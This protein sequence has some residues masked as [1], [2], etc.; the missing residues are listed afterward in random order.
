MDE[1]GITLARRYSGGGAVYQDLGCTTFTFLHEL[2]GNEPVSRI[3]DSNFDMLVSAFRSLNLPVV[4]KGRND[5]VVDDFKVSGSAFKQTSDRLIHH[6]TILVTTDLDRLGKFLTPSKLKLKSKGIS[7]VAARVS[8]LSKFNSSVE[9]ESVCDAIMRQFRTAH[10]CTSTNDAEIIDVSIQSDPTFV[11]HHDRLR[12]WK[13]RYGSSPHF[14][15]TV[16]TRIEGIGM[17]E[18][19]YEVE[20]GKISKIKIFSDVLVPEIVEQLETT[21]IE[22]EYIPSR[23]SEALTKLSDIQPDENRKIIVEE[24]MKWL[25]YEVSH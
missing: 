15:H 12:D 7:S 10:G 3:I 6:G 20:Q 14:S 13:W 2:D 11:R 1:A 16:E 18:C 5:L 17:F 23:I 25:L 22:C 21:L 8:N 19:L 24:F 9:H 4:R